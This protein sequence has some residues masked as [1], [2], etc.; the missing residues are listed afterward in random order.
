M[1]LIGRKIWPLRDLLPHLRHWH[2]VPQR[3]K[4]FDVQ[5]LTDS[6]GTGYFWV[7]NFDYDYPYEGMVQVY[8]KEGSGDTRRDHVRVE[9]DVGTPGSVLVHVPGKE[10][11]TVDAR[12]EIPLSLEPGEGQLFRI[13]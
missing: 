7:T 13:K 10:A 1:K 8:L 11:I 6:A 9:K 5:F 2:S 12:G 3:N 4:L